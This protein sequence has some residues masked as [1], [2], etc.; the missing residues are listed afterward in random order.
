MHIAEIIPV[1]NV[2]PNGEFGITLALIIGGILAGGV[3][4]GVI[5][6]A[7]AAEGE[8]F[9]SAALGGFINGVV[10]GIGL[11]AGLAVSAIG[12]LPFLIAGGVIA[13]ASGFIGGFLGNATTQAISYGDVDWK[14]ASIA[15]AIS[16]GT[17]LMM[18]IGLQTAGMSSTA[19]SFLKRVAENLA[20]DIIPLGVS[21][22]LGTLPISNP[23]D[24][25][26]KI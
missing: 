25:R 18:F 16:A 24:L 14:V 1:M 6:G 10:S 17:N 8:G 9:W 20:L 21:F 3:I 12:G 5:A 19:S 15:G 4:N 7:N 13:T 11:A 22:Y 23:N 2:D 26:G